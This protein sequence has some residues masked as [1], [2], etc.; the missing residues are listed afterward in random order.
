MESKRYETESEI[1][2]RRRS[3]NTMPS[4][5]AIEKQHRTATLDEALVRSR[6]DMELMYKSGHMDQLAYNT[7]SD[8]IQRLY[9]EGCG[10]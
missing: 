6:K 3:A 4:V 2:Q 8:D 5:D 9:I 10:I 7:M 1:E